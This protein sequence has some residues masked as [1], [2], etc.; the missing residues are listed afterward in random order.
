M[1]LRDDVLVALFHH[2]HIPDVGGRPFRFSSVS[3]LT[4]LHVAEGVNDPQS[5]RPLENKALDFSVSTPTC[6]PTH[7]IQH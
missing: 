3:V 5:T 1:D 7:K 6:L 4:P 2:L